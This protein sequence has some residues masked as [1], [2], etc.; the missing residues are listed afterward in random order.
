MCREHLLGICSMAD[1]LW[2]CRCKR[3][4]RFHLRRGYASTWNGQA[5][6]PDEERTRYH[7]AAAVWVEA[8]NNKLTPNFEFQDF[9]H[10]LSFVNSLVACF[11]TIDHHPDV[12]IA[13]GEVMFELT[14]YDVCEKVTDR[15]VEIAKTISSV[16]RAPVGALARTHHRRRLEV[17]AV[18]TNACA[19]FSR[20]ALHLESFAFRGVVRH[21]TVFDL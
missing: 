20:P 8:R 4:T 14:Q 12:C 17:N 9:V 19:S 5:H 16:Y 15:Y 2:V 1:R 21:E 3:R 7:H 11:E 18:L 6:N 13:Y 10:S